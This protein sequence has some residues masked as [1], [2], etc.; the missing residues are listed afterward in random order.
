MLLLLL[1]LIVL[2]LVITMSPGTRQIV[3]IAMI[4]L[5]VLILL[6]GTDWPAFPHITI[7]RG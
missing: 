3:N 4:V 6:F 7:G 2:C 5:V 1:I